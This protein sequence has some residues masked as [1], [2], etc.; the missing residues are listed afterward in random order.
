MIFSTVLHSPYVDILSKF[1]TRQLN[2]IISS[3]IKGDY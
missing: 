2:L 3:L 1:N